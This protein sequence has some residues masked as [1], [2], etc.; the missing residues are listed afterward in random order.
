MYLS[1]D[2]GVIELVGDLP[3]RPPVVEFSIDSLLEE[4]TLET[5]GSKLSLDSRVDPDLVNSANHQADTS[6]TCSRLE[7]HQP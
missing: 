3:G 2:Q 7:V 4:S 5:T 1:E 6:R